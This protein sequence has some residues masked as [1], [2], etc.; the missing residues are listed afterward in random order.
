MNKIL[1][2]VLSAAVIA[3]MAGCSTP[4]SSKTSSTGEGKTSVV[5]EDGTKSEDIC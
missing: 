2:T 5:A 3:S 4:A 1:S